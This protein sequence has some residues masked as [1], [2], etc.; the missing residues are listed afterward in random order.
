MPK[1]GRVMANLAHFH[2]YFFDFPVDQA[3]RVGQRV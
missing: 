1:T 3:E 2:F